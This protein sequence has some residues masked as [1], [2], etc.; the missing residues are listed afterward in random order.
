MILDFTVEAVDPVAYQYTCAVTGGFPP[1]H[2]G[3]YWI[4]IIGVHPG[5]SYGNQRFWYECVADDYWGEEGMFRLSFWGYPDW[6]PMSARWRHVEYAFVLYTGGDTP[7]EHSSGRRS[8]RC[9]AS[10]RPGLITPGEHQG[11]GLAA[12][13][14]RVRRRAGMRQWPRSFLEKTVKL[15][16]HQTC[17]LAP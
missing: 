7:V 1:V 15:C 8:R 10:T 2:G 6:S 13:V 14:L 4:G 17:L 3:T 12:G 5:P 11:L 9:S 16:Y